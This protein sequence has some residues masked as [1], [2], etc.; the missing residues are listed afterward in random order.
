MK[1]NNYDRK[2]K[3]EVPWK[4]LGRKRLVP[5]SGMDEDF[6]QKMAKERSP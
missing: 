4:A 2:V 6:T 1:R 3:Y 5:N